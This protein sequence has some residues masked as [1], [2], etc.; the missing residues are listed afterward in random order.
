MGVFRQIF[1]QIFRPLI[2]E[3]VKAKS[4]RSDQV[5]GKFSASFVMYRLRADIDRR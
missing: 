3:M 2:S 5:M 1:R 4:W